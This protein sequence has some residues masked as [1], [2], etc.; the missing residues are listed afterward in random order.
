MPIKLKLKLMRKA[1]LTCIPLLKMEILG[2]SSLITLQFR[3]HLT[4]T[5]RQAQKPSS[6]PKFVF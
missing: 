4:M 3:I 5:Q 2:S 1:P 6:H